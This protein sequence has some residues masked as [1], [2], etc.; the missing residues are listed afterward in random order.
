MQDNYFNEECIR[1]SYKFGETIVQNVCT[2]EEVRVPWE[3][4]DWF[5]FAAIVVAAIVV[6]LE[7]VKALVELKEGK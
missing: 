2:L 1:S 7:L 3:F 4:E 6:Y 5:G